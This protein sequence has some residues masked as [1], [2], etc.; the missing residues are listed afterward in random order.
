MTQIGTSG[1]TGGVRESHG[2]L[3]VTLTHR[4]A[5]RVREVMQKEHTTSQGLRVAVKSGC[6]GMMQYNLQFADV[7]ADLDLVDMQYGIKVFVDPESMDHVR[8]MVIDYSPGLQG[9]GFKFENP[10]VRRTCGC[11]NSFGTT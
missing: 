10:N 7:T 1:N 3:P 9:Q 4:A 5:E 6:S 2:G 8:G 11:G